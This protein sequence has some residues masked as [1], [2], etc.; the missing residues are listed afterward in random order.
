MEI[1]ILN[2]IIMDQVKRSGEFTQRIKYEGFEYTVVNCTG[3][4]ATMDKQPAIV[5][6]VKL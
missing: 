5:N 4:N 3:T 6:K 1:S 2:K